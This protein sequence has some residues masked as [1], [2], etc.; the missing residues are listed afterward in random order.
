M[1]H[2]VR[3]LR[4]QGTFKKEPSKHACCMLDVTHQII[5]SS[6]LSRSPWPMFGKLARVQGP[7]S[8]SLLSSMCQQNTSFEPNDVGSPQFLH[9]LQ[10]YT[11]L[12]SSWAWMAVR[13]SLAMKTE[14][15][16]GG[17]L[18]HFTLTH[19]EFKE[20]IAAVPPIHQFSLVVA[21]SPLLQKVH[22]PDGSV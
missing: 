7:I 16:T 21:V 10:Q 19:D 4:S 3:F 13:P 14:D 9:K 1:S 22:C 8:C 6:A 11:P 12:K 15:Q 20:C 17:E 18:T 5:H 2:H